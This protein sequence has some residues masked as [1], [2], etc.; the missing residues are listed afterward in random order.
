GKHPAKTLHAAWPHVFVQMHDYFG[1]AGGAKTMTSGLEVLAQ[2]A[3]VVN[4]AVE[5]DPDGLVLVSDGLVAG[6]EVDD[7]QTPHAQSDRGLD[8][9]PEVIGAP[10]RDPVAHCLEGR[11]GDGMPGIRVDDARYAAHDRALNYARVNGTFGRHRAPP[12]SPT[13]SAECA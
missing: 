5:D 11:Q 9:V 10:V 2:S 13:T 4:F 7:A 12:P 3:I 1:V 6:P 8:V